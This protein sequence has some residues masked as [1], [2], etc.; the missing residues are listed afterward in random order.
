M[1]RWI[2]HFSGHVQGVGFRATVL[3][4]ARR[5]AVTGSVRNLADGR[6]ALVAEGDEAVLSEFVAEI[7]DRMS[8][9]VTQ[10]RMTREVAQGTLTDFRIEHD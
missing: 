9:H 4:L 1:Q 8:D 3:R 2:V 6:V 10:M 7:S 5:H